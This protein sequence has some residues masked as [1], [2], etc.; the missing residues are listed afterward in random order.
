MHRH[1]SCNNVWTS[2]WRGD[3]G[4]D[5]SSWRSVQLGQLEDHLRHMGNGRQEFR[6]GHHIASV[7]G[8]NSEAFNY[9]NDNLRLGWYVLLLGMMLTWG[10]LWR[11]KTS[12]PL[13]VAHDC[14]R[15]DTRVSV[16]LCI[17][18][19]HLPTTLLKPTINPCR[20]IDLNFAASP[21]FL[22][23]SNARACCTISSLDGQ[24]KIYWTYHAFKNCHQNTNWTL[25]G[26]RWDWRFH[27]RLAVVC[28]P[29]SGDNSKNLEVSWGT[30][31]KSGCTSLL[32]QKSC[33]EKACEHLRR[34]QV[35]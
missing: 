34:T 11:N 4:G 20:A 26:P 30:I 24:A 15:L 2:V 8:I 3:H 12:S 29:R 17:L 35:G 28:C 1:Q 13:S 14:P 10:H 25:S 7:H 22:A 18:Y 19:P 23:K 16:R 33:N 27:M 32:L 21:E 31:G 9:W 6:E 5:P